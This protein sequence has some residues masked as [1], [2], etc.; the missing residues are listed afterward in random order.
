MSRRYQPA[1]LAAAVNIDFVSRRFAM[2]ERPR[3]LPPPGRST[4]QA[5]GRYDMP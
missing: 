4:P 2:N 1:Q 3:R 5:N